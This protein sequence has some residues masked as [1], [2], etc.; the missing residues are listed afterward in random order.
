MQL[1][2]C[3]P[4]AGDPGDGLREMALERL[5]PVFE[6]LRQ[7][8]SSAA[9]ELLTLTQSGVA[10]LLQR[11]IG[12]TAALENAGVILRSAVERALNGAFENCGELTGFILECIHKTHANSLGTSNRIDDHALRD[13]AD[14]FKSLCPRDRQIL[15]R[16]FRFRHHPDR[17]C[18]DFGISREEF[19]GVVNGFRSPRGRARA[20]GAG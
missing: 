9:G 20:A 18:H 6:R 1:P 10:L 12:K 19:A 11:K 3:G 5:E 7:G 2:Y 4:Y 15:A 14:R 17:I 8:D 13:V 16:Y